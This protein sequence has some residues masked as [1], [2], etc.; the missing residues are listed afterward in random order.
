QVTI[1]SRPGPN[2]LDVNNQVILAANVSAAGRVTWTNDNPNLITFPDGSTLVTG[3][4]GPTFLRMLVNGPG[5]ATITATLISPCGATNQSASDSF[6][7]VLSDDVTAVGWVSALP[8]I[9]KVNQ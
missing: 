7:F 2:W 6:T 5:K 4:A 3:G 8:G 1:T 9:D